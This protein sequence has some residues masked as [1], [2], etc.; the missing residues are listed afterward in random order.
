M[1]KYYVTKRAPVAAWILDDTTPFHDATGRGSTATQTG[2]PTGSGISSPVVD[3]AAYSTVF[4]KAAPG[5]FQSKLFRQGYEEESF[6]LEAWVLPVV[7]VPGYDQ[8][9]VNLST[10]P[11]GELDNAGW[12]ISGDGAFAPDVSTEQAATGNQSIKAV[13]S[14]TRSVNWFGRY[15]SGDDLIAAGVSPGVVSVR[16]K[17]WIPSIIPAGAGGFQFGGG[18][19]S[20]VDVSGSYPSERDQWTDVTC[21]AEWDGTASGV[22]LAMD[23]S[24]TPDAYMYVDDIRIVPGAEPPTDYFDGDTYGALWA[25]TPHASSS[26]MPASTGPQQVLSHDSFYDGL[27]IDGTVI[28]FSTEYLTAPAAECTYDLQERKLAHVVGQHTKDRNELWVNG[29]LVDSV[30]LTEDQITD[31][32]IATD[33]Y[34]YCGGTD[35]SSGVAVNGVAIYK[36][37]SGLD[38]ERNYLAGT[39]SLGQDTVTTQYG[40]IPLEFDNSHADLFISEVWDSEEE[41]NNGSVDN[42]TVTDEG[43]LP[44]YESGISVAGSWINSIPLDVGGDTSIYGVYIEWVGNDI[45]VETSLDG[46]TWT[47]HVSGDPVAAITEGFD[48]TNQDLQVRVNFSGGLE[49]DPAYLT[50]LSVIGIRTGVIESISGRDLTLSGQAMVRNG[51]GISLYR[52]DTGIDL[53]GGSVSVGNDTN[54]DVLGMRAV[55]FWIKP[56]SSN[57]N[58]YQGQAM[59]VNG[60]ATT[61]LPVGKWSLVHIDLGENFDNFHADPGFESGDNGYTSFANGTSEVDTTFYRS[62]SQSLKHI[63]DTADGTSHTHSGVL[64][65]IPNGVEG[66]VTASAWF[67]RDPSN[68]SSGGAGPLIRIG[69]SGVQP[70]NSPPAELYDEWEQIVFS[71]NIDA[72]GGPAVMYLYADPG[73]N[74]VTWFDDLTFGVSYNISGDAVV[75]Q[76]NIYPEALTASQVSQ[77]WDS[78]VGRGSLKVSDS[79]LAV[80]ESSPPAKVYSQDWAIDSA[81]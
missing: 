13:A 24:Q 10:N 69:A 26:V 27:S 44:A 72:D 63:H 53:N 66:R 40:G 75:G 74:D 76:F 70:D 48:P 39:D 81:G 25:G 1:Y 17:V 32:Y 22:L 80:S 3:G 18:G 58:F 52:D 60:V 77:I 65:T 12:T 30:E 46:S 31:D 19:S 9:E 38:I 51:H 11:S 61:E 8:E 78:Y 73:A 29:V 15:K 35:S 59:Y 37:M 16:A 57:V 4:E 7:N 55:E 23:T 20:A 36:S 34:L 62:G 6:A 21:T 33:G 41:F 45:S 14:S 49:D 42:V 71:V 43:L 50:S 47:P 5:Q 56:E 2:T 67:Y 79:G 54:D 64:Y 28:K 68:T